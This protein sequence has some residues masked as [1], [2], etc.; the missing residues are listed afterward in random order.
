MMLVRRRM[1]HFKTTRARRLPPK[2]RRI[3]VCWYA[4]GAL[5]GGRKDRD[6][7][8]VRQALLAGF[9]FDDNDVE[10]DA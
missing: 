7:K 8:S 3:V 10:T 2:P 6:L 4:L 9:E 1:F 5:T